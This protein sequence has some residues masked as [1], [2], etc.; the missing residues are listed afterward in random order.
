MRGSRGY[1]GKTNAGH[2]RVTVSHGFD[3]L[4]GKR[5]QAFATVRGTREDAEKK[6]TE[7]LRDADESI[8]PDPG[9]ETVG[10]YLEG[11][12]A[13]ARLKNRVRVRTL[14]R[15]G[16]LLRR[17]VIP[18]IGGVKLAK[19]D[20]KVHV[21]LVVD[22][23]RARGLSE[24]TLLHICRV[25]QTA[26]QDAVGDGALKTNRAILPKSRRPKPTKAELNIPTQDGVSKLIAAAAGDYRLHFPVLLVATTGMRRG[27]ALAARWEDL[28]LD[29]GILSVTGSLQRTGKGL[30]ERVPP[31]T[32]RS[33]RT[34]TLPPMT[35][36][37]LRAHRK[38]QAERRL[39]LGTRWHATDFIF[40]RGDGR[41]LDPDEFSGLFKLLAD[42][43]A[44]G[45]RFHD[46]RHAFATTL[47]RRGVHP[48]IVSEALGHSSVG[49]TLDTYSHVWPGMGS[50]AADA[51]QAA[52]EEV[53]AGS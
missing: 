17:H 33:R 34:V 29:R 47:A 9:R 13:S 20:A 41:P 16:Q 49:I 19:L 4:S 37:A 44:P 27:E 42:R 22:R 46:L 50:V 7:M 26:I 53:A 10:V 40:D 48:K 39:A 38:A 12:L 8:P 14:E 11:W 24:R 1:I 35:V 28:D 6:L 45:V 23:A 31:K 51:I 3:K 2:W 15:Y 30:L 36:V 25:F 5:R 21:G 18:V 43:V 52:F 32:A